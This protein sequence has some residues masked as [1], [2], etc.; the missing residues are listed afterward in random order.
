MNVERYL[1]LIAGFFVMASVALGYWVQSQLVS[2]HGIRR[3][4]PVSIGI[5]QL[6][7]H[8]HHS[9]KAR[10]PANRGLT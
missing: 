4:E 6:V 9:A 7:S 10:R 3:A 2:V 1:R 5:H 8:D